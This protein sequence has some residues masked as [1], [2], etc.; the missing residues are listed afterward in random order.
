M[1]IYLIDPKKKWCKANLH[2]HTCHSDGFFTPEQMKKVY[3]EHGYQII[4]FTD[5]EMIFDNSDLTDE[6]FVAITSA[7]YSVYD[8]KSPA[9]STYV[10]KDKKEVSWRDAKTIHLCMFSKDPHNTM[11]FATS[12]EN[13]SPYMIDKYATYAHTK[14]K[15]DGYTRKFTK[16]SIQETID[17][18]NKAGF[19]V[20]FNHPN[21]S[22]NTRDDYIN[23]KGLW[24][25]EIL[26][27]AT[28][29][30][31]GSD[32]CPN[33]Y[34][35]MIRYGHKIVCTMN[36]DNHNYEGSLEGSFGG[37]N[38]IGVD[39]LNYENVINAMEKGDIY[40]SNGP[41]IKSLY[42][43]TDDGKFY[44]ETSEAESII[45]VGYNRIFRH[46]YGENITKGDFKIFG[47]EVYF[48]FCVRDKY[49]RTAHTHAYFLKDYGYG[50]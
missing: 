46:Y 30:E 13:I 16:E 22:L 49:G 38:Y 18:A 45:M 47:D 37:F 21:W 43:D 31:T 19:L 33:L 29:L 5:H 26:N 2:C 17:R 48:R 34:D 12:E 24:G 6:N 8:N 41:I 20:Q 28:E 23:L 39:K 32:Y 10:E 40:C 14:M 44:I 4:A 42:L 7:E 35:D 27:Y 11:H 25:F 9:N 15:Y 50:K 36:D 1:K 3:M